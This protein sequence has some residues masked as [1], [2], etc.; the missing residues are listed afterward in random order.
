MWG[1]GLALSTPATYGRLAAPGR[2]R[3][4]IMQRTKSYFFKLFLSNDHK[5]TKLEGAMALPAAVWIRSHIKSEMVAIS[6]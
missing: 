3:E 6:G 4:Q 1:Y 5:A 2:E